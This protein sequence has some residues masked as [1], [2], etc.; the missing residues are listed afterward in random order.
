M[1]I[2]MPKNVKRLHRKVQEWHFRKDAEVVG[3]C[4]IA[5]PR[6][7]LMDALYRGY[8]DVAAGRVLQLETEDQIDA[9]FAA[10]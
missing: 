5:T 3:D 2:D 4:A 10:R 8:D 9:L 6:A 7:R 1:E